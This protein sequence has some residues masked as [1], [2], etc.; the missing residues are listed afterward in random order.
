MKDLHLNLLEYANQNPPSWAEDILEHYSDD[1][2]LLLF[3]SSKY[4]CDNES[5]NIHD[6]VGTAHGNYSDRSW[7]HLLNRGIRMLNINLPLLASNP[8][9]Y[10]EVARKEPKMEYTT[11]D[12][13]TYIHMEGNHRTCIARFYFY[14]QGLTTL[15]GVKVEKHFIDHSFKTAYEHLEK[16][17]TSAVKCKMEVQKTTLNR[18][19]TAGWCREFYETTAMLRTFKDDRAYKLTL[20]DIYELLLDSQRPFK[21]LFGKYKELWRQK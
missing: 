20:P 10:L 1:G 21:G 18:V 4:W 3:E 7:L 11:V 2:K 15:H 13:K 14:Y 17:V 19:D 8:N 5:I 6:I 12:D 16:I 9:Y